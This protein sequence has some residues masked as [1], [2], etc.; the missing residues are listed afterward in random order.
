M[1]LT[2]INQM[3]TLKYLFIL[4][5]T[6]TQERFM[7]SVYSFEKNHLCEALVIVLDYICHALGF[8]WLLS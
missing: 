3:L 1:K 5:N 2:H 6:K 4:I 8:Y 7:Y